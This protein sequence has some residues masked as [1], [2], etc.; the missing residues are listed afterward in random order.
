MKLGLLGSLIQ[1]HH[2]HLYNHTQVEDIIVNQIVLGGMLKQDQHA[3]TFV[4][5]GGA[6]LAAIDAAAAAGAPFDVVLLDLQ[7]PDMHGLEVLR[8]LRGHADA[9]RAALPVVVVSALALD[10]EKEECARAGADGFVSK[11]IRLPVL[12][13]ELRRLRASG[14]LCPPPGAGGAEDAGRRGGGSSSSSRS[15]GPP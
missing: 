3:A 4:E 15:S 1:S 7:L 10:N 13:E 6:A 11:P 2:R 8:A 9:R 5:T 12:R 14:R